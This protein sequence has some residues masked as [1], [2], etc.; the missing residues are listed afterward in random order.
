LI[1]EVDVDADSGLG[2]RLLTLV[3]TFGG[4]G[5]DPM[6]VVFRI[7][8]PGVG[9]ADPGGEVAVD[10]VF[11]FDID[12]VLSVGMAGVEFVFT[13][14][15]VG[16]LEVVTDRDSGL[17]DGAAIEEAAEVGLESGASGISDRGFLVLATGSA[18]KGALGG[19]VGGGLIFEGRCIIVA[20]AV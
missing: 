12:V 11:V 15:G 14:L 5:N 16:K 4:A 18:G 13:G 2:G 3:L 17:F 1:S 7:V 9:S 6:L 10:V 8:L 20:V 19:A